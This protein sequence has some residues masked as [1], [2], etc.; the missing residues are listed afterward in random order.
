MGRSPSKKCSIMPKLRR[1]KTAAEDLKSIWRYIADRNQTAADK[2]NLLLEEK[3][4]LLAKMP[5]LGTCVPELGTDLRFFTV[6]VYVIVYRATS[7]NVT[8]VRILHGARDFKA[9]FNL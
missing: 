6:G 8:I 2:H 7:E 5:E 3:V 9:L 1:S 4:R